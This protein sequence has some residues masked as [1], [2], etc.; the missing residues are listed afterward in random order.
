MGYDDKI[1]W[2]WRQYGRY[3]SRFWIY[4]ARESGASGD[5]FIFLFGS[6]GADLF[7]D[8]AGGTLVGFCWNVGWM[9]MSSM[10]SILAVK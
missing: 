7:D 5:I 9:Y 4:D 6:A 2:L 3:D 1:Y 8:E 10:S